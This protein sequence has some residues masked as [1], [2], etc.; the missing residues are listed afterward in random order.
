MTRI[1]LY[2]WPCSHL[3]MRSQ[4]LAQS[5]AR[6]SHGD[7]GLLCVCRPTQPA[8]QNINQHYSIQATSSSGK[9]S[10]LATQQ[11]EGSPNFRLLIIT[12]SMVQKRPSVNRYPFHPT[13]NKKQVFMNDKK[14][15]VQKKPAKN[16]MGGKVYLLY[17]KNVYNKKLF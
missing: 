10:L 7:W 13:V 5:C 16:Y 17:H 9:R 8:L 12:I 15:I 1:S 6:R 11:N 4:Q 2:L 3:S 14:S